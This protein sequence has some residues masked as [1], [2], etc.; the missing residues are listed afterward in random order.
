[1]TNLVELAKAIPALD[2]VAVRAARSRQRQLTKPPGSLGRL[3]EVSIQIA[4]IQGTDRPHIARKALVIAAGDHGVTDQRVTGYPSEVT[5]QM[6]GTFLWGGAAVNVLA[7]HNN[8]SITIVDAGV[9]ADVL[10]NDPRLRRLAIG[11]GTHDISLGPAMTEEMATRCVATGVE[12]GGEVAGTGAD[13]IGVGE[14]GIGNTTASSA[15]VAVMTS[16][17]PE[18]TTGAGTGRTKEQLLHKIEVVRRAL[19]VNKPDGSDPIGV[20]A[21]IGGFEIGLLAGVMIGAAAQR[22]IDGFIT[23]AAAL[24]ACA[25]APGV[26]HYLIASHRSSERGHRVALHA[27]GLRPLLDLGMR[28]GEGTGAVLG[29]SVIEM[30]AACLSEMA[31]FSEAGVDGGTT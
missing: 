14:M 9:R 7:R 26:R 31:T 25:I 24:L 28:L 19:E 11:K 17:G 22:R 12:I 6:I 5:A 18:H 13:A 16:T 15:I 10:P 29:M 20:L 8:V 30:A 27:L 1:M 21:R 4:G 23:S 2:Q 3:E